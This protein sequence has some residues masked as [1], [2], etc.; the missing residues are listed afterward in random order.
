MLV[1]MVVM[2][3]IWNP[4]SRS[5]YPESGSDAMWRDSPQLREC[6]LSGMHPSQRAKIDR[7]IVICL[8]NTR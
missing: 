5:M 8:E 2:R 6:T 3:S 4:G 1:G 7:S